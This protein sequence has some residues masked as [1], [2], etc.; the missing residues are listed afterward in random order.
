MTDSPR[1]PLADGSR[2]ASDAHATL[3]DTGAASGARVPVTASPGPALV[4][5]RYRL[6]RELGRGGAAIVWLARDESADREVAVKILRAEVANTV[7]SD[8]FLEEIRIVTA[9]SHPRLLPILD[10]GAWEGL[11]FYVTPYVERGSLRARLE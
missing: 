5:S 6:V 10:S 1:D 9:L 4:A 7:A 2:R 3:A 8:R 11:L